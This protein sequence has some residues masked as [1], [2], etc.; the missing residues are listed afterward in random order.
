M[1][2]SDLVADILVENEINIAFAIS[3]GA[4]L[5]LIH[6][7]EEKSG[8][9]IFYPQH[10]QAAAMAADGYNRVSR[11]IGCAIATSGPG[12]TNL[13]TGMSSSFYDSVP[14]LFLTGQV[15][16]FRAK[17]DTGVRQLGFQETEII[18][19][20]RSITKY[21]VLI[22]DPYSI[23]YELEKAID[24]A[25][26]GRPGPVLID[27]PDDI[28]RMEINPLNVYE[29]RSKTVKNKFENLINEA[30]IQLIINALKAAKRPVIIL[31]WGVHLAGAEHLAIK[32]S[33]QT[34]IPIALTWG[35]R[36][37]IEENNPLLIGGFGTHGTRF[38]NFAVQNS[39]FILSIGSR[40][41][42]KATGSPPSS[43][44]REA[45]I[46]MVD[47]DQ[48]EINKFEKLGRKI[49]HGI[50]ADA[51][52]FLQSLIS[53]SNKYKFPNFYEWVDKIKYWKNKYPIKGQIKD[54]AG[55]VEPYG[56]I[57]VLSG[58]LQE[59]CIIFSDTGCGLA[60]MMQ[61][62]EFKKGQ[63]FFHAFN[64]TPMGYGLPGA[65]GAAFASRQKSIVLIT[66]DGSLQMSIQ[67]LATIVRHNLSVKIILLNNHGHGMVRQTQDMWL[68]GN[69][70]ATSVKGGLPDPNFI[71]IAR[72]YGLMSDMLN[73][74]NQVKSKVRE[75]I[76]H[77]GPYLLNVEINLESKVEP[78]VKYGRPNEDSDPLLSREEFLSNMFIPPLIQ[79]LKE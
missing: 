44:A 3:G 25:R 41:D 56:L 14:V 53:V 71:L 5:H 65:I 33:K 38:A 68:S 24:I 77:E 70:Y 59:G 23:K 60:W 10:E 42:S 9:D 73:D 17:G 11:K 57:K 45:K 35:A 67:E 50:Q 43:F 29:F 78:Q 49:D 62:F 21:A 52:N 55:L 79:S 51:Y 20:C 34:G 6:S 61:A 18:D 75:L 48:N 64:N 7:I 54:S 4:S 72:S 36:D 27:I 37:L 22:K 58:E 66:G 26:S 19:I 28:Q 46:V 63:R 8:I 39:D 15:A 13:V 2:F 31:G 74:Q 32:F 16:T 69:H 47:I 76:S 40:L 1:K 12:A 30:S